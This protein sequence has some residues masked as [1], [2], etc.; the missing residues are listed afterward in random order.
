[1]A[2]PTNNTPDFRRINRQDLPG[3][4]S[5]VDNLLSPINL[6]FEQTYAL[7]DG[8]LNFYNITGSQ[9]SATFTTPANYNDGENTNFNAFSFPITFTGASSVLVGTIDITSNGQKLGVKPVTI[10]VGG[11]AEQNAGKITI[12][13]ITGLQPN[14]SY[15]VTFLCF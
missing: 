14:T 5:W 9:A 13:Y 15:N 3:S 8:E 7:L 1:M 2:Q 6:F 4:P 10:P 12:G 11:W